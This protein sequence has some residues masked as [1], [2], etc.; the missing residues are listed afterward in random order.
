VLLEPRTIGG[1]GN[2]LL[3][4]SAL[5]AAGVLTYLVKR[6]DEIAKALSVTPD[7]AV[8]GGGP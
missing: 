4:Y 6:Q 7:G 1:E 3:V 8:M 2:A 5:A